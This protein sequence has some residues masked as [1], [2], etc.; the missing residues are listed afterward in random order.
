M[1]DLAMALFTVLLACAPFVVVAL[2]LCAEPGCPEVVVGSRCPRHARP[3]WP[4][5]SSR[6]ER[7]YGAPWDRLRAQVLADEPLCPCGQ[8][9]TT[10]D[11]IVPRTS[12][13]TDARSNLRALCAGCH[14]T[15][16][17]R[18]GRAASLLFRR[19]NQA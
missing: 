18:E 3:A 12:G 19:R 17:A 8:P 7:G 9:A 2:K 1:A 6:H 16:S 4:H 5:Q 11:H 15:K 13:G 14:A 10:V